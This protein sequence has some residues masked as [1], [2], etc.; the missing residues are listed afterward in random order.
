MVRWIYK[1]CNT[2]NESLNE[3]TITLAREDEIENDAIFSEQATEAKKSYNDKLKEL[4][5]FPITNRLERNML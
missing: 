4:D 2:S 1:G 5:I 3:I